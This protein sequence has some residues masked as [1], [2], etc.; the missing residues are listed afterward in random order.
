M[1]VAVIDIDTTIANNDHRAIYLVKHCTDCG[2]EVSHEHR[3]LCSVCGG[4]SATI[5]QESWDKFL[6]PELI[7]KDTAQPHALDVI[8]YMRSHKWRV[9]FL[10]GRN[11]SL[12]PY[13]IKWLL[14]NMAWDSTHEPLVM[15]PWDAVNIPASVIKEQL[16]LDNVLDSRVSAY[17]FFEDD[18]HVLG[19]WR[20]YG[21]VYLCPQAWE[22]MNPETLESHTEPAWKR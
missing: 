20:K 6:T 13:T 12:R 8:N 1:N 14:D 15:R 3:A 18:K 7:V 16:F 17:H 21:M 22:Y 9:V 4:D 2:S 19:T 11:M 10:T 5:S